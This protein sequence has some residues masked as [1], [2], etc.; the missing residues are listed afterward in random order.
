VK[1]PMKKNPSN[2]NLQQEVSGCA[3][4]VVGPLMLGRKMLQHCGGCKYLIARHKKGPLHIATP[5]GKLPRRKA[6][7]L[8]ANAGIGEA[9][10][11]PRRAGCGARLGGE[12]WVE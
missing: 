7:G 10:K 3:S 8:G 6:S 12:Y 11:P 5:Q 9:E 1:K 2:L 4:T